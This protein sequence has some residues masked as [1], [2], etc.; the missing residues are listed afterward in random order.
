M[1][2]AYETVCAMRQEKRAANEGMRAHIKSEYIPMS[3]CC[4]ASREVFAKGSWFLHARASSC[5]RL[6]TVIGPLVQCVGAVVRRTCARVPRDRQGEGKADL[7]AAFE[8]G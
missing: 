3:G 1:D 7:Q 5:P 2:H 6:D 4:H 8:G